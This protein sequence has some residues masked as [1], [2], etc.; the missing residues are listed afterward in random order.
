LHHIISDLLVR[1]Q[2]EEQLLLLKQLSSDIPTD[3]NTN[4]SSI[5]L[6]DENLSLSQTELLDSSAAKQKAGLASKGSLA[7]RQPPSMRR[8]SST[9]SVKVSS[10]CDSPR[11]QISYTKCETEIVVKSD[12]TSPI[13]ETPTHSASNQLY[14]P[15]AD[16]I[17]TQNNRRVSNTSSSPSSF[18]SSS[19]NH[20]HPYPTQRLSAPVSP[21]SVH[22]SS[23]STSLNSPI[24]AVDDYENSPKNYRRN[25]HPIYEWNVD[26]VSQWLVALNLNSYVNK[27]QENKISGPF[28]LHLDSTQLKSLGVSNSTDRSL[29]K[30]KIKEF[31]AEVERE[32][33]AL[34]KEQKVR[35]RLMKKEDKFRKK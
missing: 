1:T 17:D 23:S 5:G 30:K 28:L 4:N 3:T 29:L 16:K 6:N 32:R 9:G 20:S 13:R 33:K 14:L 10:D 12:P 2:S 19:P 8:H 26:E 21:N 31:K 34:E 15:I 25:P 18:T 35:E 27:F 24:H 7:N 22:S 11:R